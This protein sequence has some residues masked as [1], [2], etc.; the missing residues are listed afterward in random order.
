MYLVRVVVDGLTRKVPDAEGHCVCAGT[1]RPRADVDAVGDVFSRAKLGAVVVRHERTT[2][3]EGESTIHTQ[4]KYI[5][6]QS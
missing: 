5:V 4:N 3:A 2:Q 6:S 1:E